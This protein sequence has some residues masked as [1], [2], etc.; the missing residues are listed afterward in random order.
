MRRAIDG[1]V[2]QAAGDLEMR[3]FANVRALLRPG[4]SLEHRFFARLT[5]GTIGLRLEGFRE[6]QRAERLAA[7]PNQFNYLVSLAGGGWRWL[8]GKKPG[9]RVHVE[10]AP[11]PGPGGMTEVLIRIEPVQ[12]AAA[13]AA[14]AL[15]ED[16]PRLL[17]SL[18]ACLQ[19]L[20]ER[21][22]QARLPFAYPVEVAPVL[23]DDRPR[24]TVVAQGRD[25]SL[26]G[27]GLSLPCRPPSMLLQL[28]LP[29]EGPDEE[30]EVPACVVRAVPRPD[31]RYDVGVRFL[32]DG[33]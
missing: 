27:M 5:P 26:R 18:R 33:A 6:E 16:G 14:R 28:R 21:R 11:A 12:C 4:R 8:L 17:H 10:S 7:E 23:P 3:E 9:L 32:L 1:L 13:E 22:Q 29:G 31:G 19:A 2:A 30:L 15:E 24:Q 20:A 25:I